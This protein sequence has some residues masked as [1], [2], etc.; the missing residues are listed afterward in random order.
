MDC[1]A[2][3]FDPTLRSSLCTDKTASSI[4]INDPITPSTE[5]FL[6]PAPSSPTPSITTSHPIPSDSQ[7]HPLS[8]LSHTRNPLNQHPLQPLPQHLLH[9]YNPPPI[10][11]LHIL[12]LIL[13]SVHTHHALIP[14][15]PDLRLLMTTPCQVLCISHP[16]DSM[17]MTGPMPSSNGFRYSHSTTT[18]LSSTGTAQFDLL[19]RPPLLHVAFPG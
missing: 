3:D 15:L 11:P 8:I 13:F 2:E 16:A 4:H 10:L 12:I 14:S 19:L 18:R 9:R 17:F 6:L 7:P 5:H 1:P